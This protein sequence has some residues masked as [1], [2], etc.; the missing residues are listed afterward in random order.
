V[1]FKLPFS[2]D[3]KPISGYGIIG[4]TR[5]CALIGFDGS[6]DWCCLPRFDSPSVFA[7]ILDHR[8]GGRWTVTPTTVSMS[9]QVYLDDTNVLT[10]RFTSRKGIVEVVDFMPCHSGKVWSTPPEIHRIVRGLS[11]EM[12]LRLVLEPRFGYGKYTADITRHEDGFL[13]ENSKE[14][15]VFSS[16]LQRLNS[17]AGRVTGRFSVKKGEK[18]YM[19]LSYGES[20][21]RRAANYSTD[22]QLSRTLRYW[23][24]W[25]SGL[26]YTGRWRK[27]VVRSALTLRLLVY[28]PTGAM[29]AAPTTSLPEA[30]GYGRNWDYRYSWIRDSAFSL[31]AFHVLGSYSEAEHYIHWLIDNNPALDKDLHLM[32]TLDGGTKI[33]ERQLTHLEGYMRSYPVRV[34]NAASAQFQLDAHGCILDALYFSYRFGVGVSEET[35]YRFVKPIANF[36]CDNWRKNGNGIW[37]IRG[38]RQHYVYTKAWCYVGLERA[39]R[40]ATMKG[41]LDDTKRWREVMDDIREEVDQKGWNRSSEY[42][43][44]SYE[45]R[46][47]DASLLLLP[48]IGFIRSDDRRM[49]RTVAAIQK[50]LSKNGLLYR[51]GIDDGLGGKEGSF[52]VCNFWLVAVL[53]RMGRLREAERLMDRLVSF[54]GP[55]GLYSEEV[56]PESGEPLG[57]FPQAFSH[58]GLISAAFEFERA[59]G[60]PHVGRGRGEG[61]DQ[62]PNS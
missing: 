26:K 41:H 34:G 57:N 31:W 39:C 55:L 25:V 29:I 54:G 60:H 13:F 12:E 1:G 30:V 56:D 51:Y 52:M 42:Y 45:T 50:K 40:I 32:Y 48:L 37:E 10:T 16:T 38:K 15:L 4:N 11:G 20:T 17:K 23:R 33:S 44:M 8:I 61:R 7:A 58:M 43:S 19:I 22:L 24:R 28:S 3:Y 5:T 14:E 53:S 27:E 6:V 2:G 35:Y 49:Q 59:L 36:I 62:K 46:E 9:T 18:V 21:P 47:P